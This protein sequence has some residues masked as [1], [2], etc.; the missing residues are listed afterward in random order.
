MKKA[1]EAVLISMAVL[2][3][4]YASAVVYAN[5][6]SNYSNYDEVLYAANR[7][8]SETPPAHWYTTEQLGIVGVTEYVGY[9]W[10][11][12]SVDPE[13]EPFPLQRELPIF[14]YKDKFYQVS[15][16]WATPSL[17]ESVIQWQVPV[18]GALGAGWVVLTGVVAIK[19]RK[20]V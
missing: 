10:I 4:I 19:W 14:I 15:P 1:V 11:H 8:E 2:T 12:I 9:S 5:V 20:P 17:I 7:Y 13:K 6:T 3:A 16:L 18:G